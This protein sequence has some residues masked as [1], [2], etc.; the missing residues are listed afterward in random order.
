MEVYYERLL[1][2][3]NIL[4]TLIIDNFHDD[5]DS[6]WITILF[7]YCYSKDETKHCTTSQGMYTNV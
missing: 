5:F 6:I 2:L 7:F 3:A 4:Q 1:K